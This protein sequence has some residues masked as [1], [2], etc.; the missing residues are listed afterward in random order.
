MEVDPELV[1][2]DD[3]KS[4]DEGAIAPW[5][6]AHVADYF[7]RLISSLA[8]ETRLQHD[9]AVALAAVG[10][11]E[12]PAVRRARAGARPLPQPVRAGAQLQRQ[13]RGHRPLHRAPARRG[14]DRHLA[15][16]VRR[17][18]ARGAVHGL[19]RRPAEADLAGRHRRRQEHRR[20]R[21]PVD[22]RGRD[23]PLRSGAVRPGEADRRAGAQGDQRAAQ[24]P[25]RRRPGLPVAEPT[26]R[27]PVGRRGP[28]DPAGH[29]DRVRPGRRAV[30][31]G[32]AEHRAAPA[33]Q[34]PADRDPDPAAQPGQHPDRGR[35]RRGHHPGGRLGRRHRSGRRRARRQRGRL[36][37]G[38]RAAGSARSR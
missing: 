25:A 4:L 1:V 20:G 37:S 16:A 19:P 18:H 8:E 34:P 28:A 9:R 33:G 15:G 29:P 3:E 11:Q 38:L 26:H 32:R 14:R 36:R 12:D 22:R 30:R 10:G 13:V 2:P 27:Q 17:L 5:S 35:A 31:A 23:L 21:Q 7:Q 6:S 24:V